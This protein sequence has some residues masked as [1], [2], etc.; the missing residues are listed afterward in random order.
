MAIVN[1]RQFSWTAPTQNTDGTDITE[2]LNYR[3]ELDGSPFLDF[4][5]VLNPDGKYYQ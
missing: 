3:L 4:P 2:A 1:P 5:G